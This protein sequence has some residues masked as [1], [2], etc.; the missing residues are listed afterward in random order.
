ML[1]IGS[2]SLTHNLHDAVLGDEDPAHAPAYVTAFADWFAQ[3]LAAGDVATLLDYRHR[4]PSALRAHPTDEH[5]LPLFVACGAAGASPRSQR[6]Y[7][8]IDDGALAM[9]VYAFHAAD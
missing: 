7:Q 8:S 3:H 2:G 9:D 5:L 1:L 6:L 4:A